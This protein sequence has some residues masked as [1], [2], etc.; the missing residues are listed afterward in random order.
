MSAL[1]IVNEKTNDFVEIIDLIGYKNDN[2]L[3][4]VNALNEPFKKISKSK[5]IFIL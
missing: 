4:G 2:K 5:V 3:S 1:E